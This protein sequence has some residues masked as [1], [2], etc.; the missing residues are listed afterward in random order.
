MIAPDTRAQPAKR[1]YDY[2][3]RFIAVVALGLIIAAILDYVRGVPD[4]YHN[5]KSRSLLIALALFGQS[6]ADEF[7]SM[8]IRWTLLGATLVLTAWCLWLSV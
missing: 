2:V 6:I 1:W 5:E 7:K 4:G 3:G 8:R